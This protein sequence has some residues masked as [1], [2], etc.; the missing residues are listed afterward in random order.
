MPDS[1]QIIWYIVFLICS[2]CQQ[3]SPTQS[4]THSLP[5]IRIR[6]R[7]RRVKAREHKD[8]DK[9]NL[10]WKSR[11]EHASKAKQEMN[12]Q[13]PLGGQCSAISRR[14]GPHHT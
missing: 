7:N 2:P 1:P 3:P 6:D 5:I 10:I 12:S 9:N 8:W 13:L 14:A 11:A 4:A